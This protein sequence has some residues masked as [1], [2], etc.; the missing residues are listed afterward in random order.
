MGC[1]ALLQGIFPN[2]GSNSGLFQS[3]AWVGG[4]FTTSV[5]T[6]EVQGTCTPS[7]KR[8]VLRSTV[9]TDICAWAA[10][11][12]AS[13]NTSVA[14]AVLHVPGEAGSLHSEAEIAGAWLNLED[15]GERS[16]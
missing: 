5:M 16:F 13:M 8:F 9:R 10:K 11:V 1:H 15:T 2:Q 3:H 6:W 4:F 12:L 14:T 7:P